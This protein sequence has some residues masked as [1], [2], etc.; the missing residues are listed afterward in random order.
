MMKAA[1][2]LVGMLMLSGCE[3]GTPEGT[4]GTETGGSAA[5]TKEGFAISMAVDGDE[6]IIVLGAA[7]GRR[8]AAVIHGKQEG[9]LVDVDLAQ[10]RFAKLAPRPSDSAPEVAVKV[11]M[12]SL[13]VDSKEGA[14]GASGDDGDPGHVKI[15]IGTGQQSISIDARDG[16]AGGAGDQALIRINGADEKA[17]RD[18]LTDQE[19]VSEK[20]RIALLS[21]LGLE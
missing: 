18:F 5:K 17:L 1:A 14:A 2:L 12:F 9:S 15:Q 4:K 21:E 20:L 10:E 7:N 6:R 19:G 16:E 3:P 11:P 13:E 8:A